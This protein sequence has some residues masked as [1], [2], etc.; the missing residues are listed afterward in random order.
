MLVPL[1]IATYLRY[2]QFFLSC[3]FRFHQ[4]QLS[5][6]ISSYSPEPLAPLLRSRSFYDSDLFSLYLCMIGLV[7]ILSIL[8][9][10]SPFCQ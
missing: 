2:V 5:H 3:L 10:L 4:T 1:P 7:D 9:I 6:P 8:S